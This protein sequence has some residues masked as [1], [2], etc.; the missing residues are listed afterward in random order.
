M[1]VLLLTFDNIANFKI[2]KLHYFVI[3]FNGFVF[4]IEIMK[5]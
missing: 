5:I 2:E 3:D 1:N 4:Y